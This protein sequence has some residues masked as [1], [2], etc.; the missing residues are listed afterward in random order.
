MAVSGSFAGDPTIHLF[1][2]SAT[3]IQGRADLDGDGTFEGDEIALKI[4]MLDGA[5]T[6]P[7]D[8]KVR[9]EQ[10]MAIDHG[11]DGN[12]HDSAATLGIAGDASGGTAG[13]G[14]VKTSTLTDNDDDTASDSATYNM[15]A[16]VVIED[17]GPIIDID[18]TDTADLDLGMDESIVAGGNTSD[19]GGSI[20]PGPDDVVG[21]TAPDGSSVF[22]RKTTAV[23][24]VA[25]LFEDDTEDAGTDG[26]KDRNLEAARELIARM[27][28]MCEPGRGE[29]LYGVIGVPSE[30]SITNKQAILDVAKGTL[31]SVMIVTEPFCVAYGMDRISDVLVV[32]QGDCG[33]QVF[34]FAAMG[35]GIRRS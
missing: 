26:E 20:D 6:D 12:D 10:I 7:D 11:A 18:V 15:T 22:G 32:D 24:D 33:H 28:E 19:E 21:V 29:S 25:D 35:N 1:R 30:A 9:V 5:T 31:D 14:V 3:E 13:V 4:T 16:D 27:V 8:A 2:I 23:G 34:C 17:D